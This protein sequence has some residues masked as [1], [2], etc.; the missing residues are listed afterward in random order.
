MNK[1]DEYIYNLIK[2]VKKINSDNIRFVKGYNSNYLEGPINGFLAAVSLGQSKIENKYIGNYISEKVKGKRYRNLVEIK[3]Y[4]SFIEG[5]SKLVDVS[6]KLMNDVLKSDT[7]NLI[8]KKEIG[9]IKFDKN[10]NA[11]YRVLSITL[12]VF[13]CEEVEKI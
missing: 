9:S 13:I 6:L 7:K 1:I 12:D 11:I 2:R 5:G 4:G 8:S 10:A 3:I